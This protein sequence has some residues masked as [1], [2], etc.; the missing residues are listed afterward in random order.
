MAV[1]KT[2]GDLT[3]GA[4]STAY[5]A[6]RHPVSTV[7]VTAGFVKGA[8]GAGVGLLKGGV[9][10]HTPQP[11]ADDPGP[12]PAVTPTETEVPEPAAVVEVP[13]RDLPGPDIVLKEVPNPDDLPEPIV[14]EAVD[15][16]DPAEHE[17]FQTE[18]KATTRADSVGGEAA[19][20]LEAEDEVDEALEESS[21]VQEPFNGQ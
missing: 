5:S 21:G 13:E 12:V 4:V 3:R 15:D 20:V 11:R 6:A 8:A 14:I 18:P 10:G 19:D 7:A 2:V 9:T 16:P 1:I 17:A